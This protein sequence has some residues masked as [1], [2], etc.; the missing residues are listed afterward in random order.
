MGRSQLL[1]KG[2]LRRQTIPS[3]QK[4]GYFQKK[5]VSTVSLMLKTLPYFVCKSFL[6]ADQRDTKCGPK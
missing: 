1:Q 3:L 5:L 4:L 2:A 6:E